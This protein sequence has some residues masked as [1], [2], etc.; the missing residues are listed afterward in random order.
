MLE[1]TGGTIVRPKDWFYSEGHRGYKYMWTLS[2]EDIAKG[3][4]YVTGYRIQTFVGVKENTG[5]TAREFVLEFVN[6]RK[7]EAA[8]VIKVCGEGAQGLFTRMCLETKEGPYH[9][10]Y[11]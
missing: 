9:V 10:L 5:M 3:G 6:V 1:P 2:R 8:R 4:S 7:K 11:A